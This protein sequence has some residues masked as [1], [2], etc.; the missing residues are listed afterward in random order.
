MAVEN[1][2]KLNDLKEFQIPSC[3][4]HNSPKA[5]WSRLEV[6]IFPL[7]ASESGGP[8]AIRQGSQDGDPRWNFKERC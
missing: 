8:E 3:E 5:A 1:S 6:N 4:S 7:S 2:R